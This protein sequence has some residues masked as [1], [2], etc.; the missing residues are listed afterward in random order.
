MI[1]HNDK[2]VTVNYVDHGI[3]KA[4][5]RPFDQPKAWYWAPVAEL[6]QVNRFGL[7][8]VV[9]AMTKEDQEIFRNVVGVRSAAHIRYTQQ[10]IAEWDI[11]LAHSKHAHRD[12]RYMRPEQRM[13]AQE[14]GS[15]F[16]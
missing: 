5:V 14:D 4:I 8:P 3:G 1:L 12:T 2:P 10:R 11:M 6:Q 9:P 13:H 16:R 15:L 7:S